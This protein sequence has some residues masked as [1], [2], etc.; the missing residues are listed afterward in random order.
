MV[1]WMYVL[2]TNKSIFNAD[3]MNKILNFIQKGSKNPPQSC[4]KTIADVQNLLLNN[5]RRL[6]FG[7]S[8]FLKQFLQC[9]FLT[10]WNNICST[11][12]EF[13]VTIPV[14]YI[15]LIF[16]IW[17]DVFWNTF[18]MSGSWQRQPSTENDWSKWCYFL[19][20]PETKIHNSTLQIHFNPN[21][22]EAG[23]S[24]RL[25]FWVRKI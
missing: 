12:F 10:L 22:E 9:I 18:G 7:H 15:F 6:I 5:F 4:G 8:N 25:L 17:D 24:W 20:V 13:Y 19:F 23:G 1:T 14:V 2:W 16:S 3:A 21:M 11:S